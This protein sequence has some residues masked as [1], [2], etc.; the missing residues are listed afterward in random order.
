MFK[1]FL[2]LL[3]CYV[4]NSCESGAADALPDLDAARVT[5][6]YSELKALWQAAKPDEPQPEKPPLA[7]ALQSASYAIA[8]EKDSARIDGTFLAQSFREGWHL[9]PLVGGEARLVAVEPAEAQV[10]WHEGKYCLLVSARGPATATLTLAATRD[11]AGSVSLSPAPAAAVTASVTGIAEGK[12]ARI[13]GIAPEMRDGVATFHLPSALDAMLLRVETPVAT[14]PLIPS[15][16]H[17]ESQIIVRYAEGRLAYRAKVYLRTDAGS[18]VSA[19]LSLPQNATGI[20]LSGDDLVGS[21]VI[22][23]DDGSRWILAEWKTRD[24]R[25]REVLLE[26]AIPQSPLAK[27]WTLHAPAPIG[28]AEAAALFVIV[29]TE[30]LELMLDNAGLPG[31][32]RRLSG[33]LAEQVGQADYLTVEAGRELNLTTRWLPRVETAQA[34]VTEAN[35]ATRLV[36]DGSMLTEASYLI[37]HKNPQDFQVELPAGGELLACHVNGATAAPI[38][39]SDTL[40]ELQLAAPGE[41]GQT[42][43]T[44]SHASRG[45]A[46]D[47][48]SG[49]V[50][51]E[52][53]RTPLFIHRLAW[54]LTIPPAYEP[55][56]I[57][58]NIEIVSGKENV[59]TLRK[60]LCRGE[61]PMAELFYQ[62]KDLSR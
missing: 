15:E 48:V 14:A 55:A 12:T 61:K 18:G 6:P 56:A 2:C 53:P 41:K 27:Q 30:G 8:L 20:A 51:V 46:L 25:D 23:A 49:Q 39:R 17:V 35:F 1:R 34:V 21:N 28:K 57:E 26:Y 43:V 13:G 47:P 59:V 32:D 10:V 45:A 40:I 33:W 38:K 3:A 58:G 22:R 29:T 50:S 37:D 52:L 11:A 36:P 16:W 62:K 60:E 9:I 24:I 7:S 4:G 5:I 31:K 42:R 19:R 54:E 44:F